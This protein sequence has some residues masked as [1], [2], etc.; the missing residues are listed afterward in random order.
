MKGSDDSW[1]H[2]GSFV[3]THSRA[4]L[5]YA[6]RRAADSEDTKDVV[7]E[8]FV[9]A[10]KRWGD[11]PDVDK[12]LPW[13]YGIAR[14]VLA[15]HYRSER[16]RL[17]LHQRA[18]IEL[19]RVPPLGASNA[20]TDAVDEALDMLRG[21]EQEVLRLAYW[22]GLTLSEIGVALGC[23]ENAAGLRLSRARKALSQLLESHNAGEVPAQQKKENVQ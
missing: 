20:G 19:S 14:R 22:E 17:R 4:V 21:E 15:N 16:R 13:L 5:R 7:A 9:V 11:R 18:A 8:T 23:S 10:W 6:L 1:K 3:E 2:Y 12:E